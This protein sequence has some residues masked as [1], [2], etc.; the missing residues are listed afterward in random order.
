MVRA[1]MLCIGEGAQILLAGDSSDALSWHTSVN[2]SQML[3][4]VLIC[5]VAVAPPSS[6]MLSL[7]P[8]HGEHIDAL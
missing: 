3:V 7:V 8:R 2:H 1:W 6:T 4:A 5:M